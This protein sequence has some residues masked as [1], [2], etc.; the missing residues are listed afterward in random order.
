MNLKYFPLKIK[1]YCLRGGVMNT[2]SDMN[3]STIFRRNLDTHVPDG[4][5]IKQEFLNEK[6]EKIECRASIF[7]VDQKYA[8]NLDELI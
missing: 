8:L 1:V 5:N 3:L 7:L 4:I 2:N 6:Y